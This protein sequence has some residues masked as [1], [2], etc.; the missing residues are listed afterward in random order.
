MPG[1]SA[2]DEAGCFLRS[3]TAEGCVTHLLSL[4]PAD[5]GWRCVLLKSGHGGAAAA[6]LE[7]LCQLAL[8]TDS[9]A[10]SFWDA[11]GRERR[12][13]VRLP[14]RKLCVLDAEVP[15]ALEAKLPGGGEEVLSLDDCRDNALLR[16]QCK[17]LTRLHAAWL[18]ELTRAARFIK[19][20]RAIKRD[21]A[22]VASE[23]LDLAKVERFAS[24]FALRHFLP[25][26]GRIGHETRR[27]LTTITGQGLLLR[28]SSL[29]AAYAD[30]VVL[31]DEYGATAPALW[32][33]VR[34]YALG[35]GL[36]VISCPCSLFPAETPEH[37]L[38]PAL[39]LCCVTSNRRHPIHFENARHMQA[40][41]F[42]QKEAL[43][44]HRGRLRFCQRT[45]RELLAE[46]YAAQAAAAQVKAG[47]DQIYAQA[48]RPGA[49]E[50]L[51]AKL[52][53]WQ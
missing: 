14:A 1:T 47:M 12:C 3:N 29:E 44:A 38:I 22:F 46:A 11:P 26:N 30:T 50:R 17:E 49:V 19:A 21:M 27:F 20:A 18:R 5:A 7:A 10:E 13:A 40:S 6:L 53:E 45:M 25:P 52:Y 39:K 43:R 16:A 24:R 35:N 28:R 23:S 15:Y 4:R 32:N 36:N 48:L 41:R 34:G 2:N 9:P 51:A 33:L 31:E 8:Q 42:L 37:L